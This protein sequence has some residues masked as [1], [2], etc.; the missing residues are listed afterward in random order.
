[1]KKFS[2]LMLVGLMIPALVGVGT[3]RAGTIA[4]I[5]GTALGAYSGVIA[6]LCSFVYWKSNPSSLLTR[7]LMEE[8]QHCTQPPE[9]WDKQVIE[10]VDKV[11]DEIAKEDPELVGK[12]I[13]DADTRTC[14]AKTVFCLLQTEQQ[15]R[16]MTIDLADLCADKEVMLRVLKLLEFSISFI[17]FGCMD[18]RT[19]TLLG[20]GIA[21]AVSILSLYLCYQQGR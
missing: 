3:A 11:L 4:T 2:K 1:M 18:S 19:M 6:G 15:V 16:G 14:A 5:C 12:V 10:A 20:G 8:S 21:S 13:A 17:K 7:W 9:E